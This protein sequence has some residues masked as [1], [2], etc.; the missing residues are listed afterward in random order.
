MKR[1]N[2]LS[3]LTAAGIINAFGP[4]LSSEKT[5]SAAGSRF[6]KM[7]VKM[8]LDV[9]Q[10]PSIAIAGVVRGRE[11]R[12]LAGYKVN[13]EQPVGLKHQQSVA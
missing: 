13:P 12:Q 10:V 5:A 1:R 4:A 11:V 6:S 9:T 7:D 3:T 2:F 8:T